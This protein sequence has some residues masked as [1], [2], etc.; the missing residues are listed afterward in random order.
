VQFN[1]NQLQAGQGSGLGLFISK[2]ICVQHGGTFEVTSQGLDC[3]ATFSITLPLFNIAN[4]SGYS[5]ND[6]NTLRRIS[7]ESI[8]S[9]A[10]VENRRPQRVLV[11]DGKDLL[12]LC[13]CVC[14]CYPFSHPSPL[15]PLSPRSPLPLLCR[16][17]L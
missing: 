7:A 2:G 6:S 17:H 9:L 14:V 1:A 10:A 3:G 8:D 13:V 12:R 16:C 15:T 4:V 11:V 5:E